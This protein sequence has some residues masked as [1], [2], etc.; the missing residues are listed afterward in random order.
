MLFEVLNDTDTS[1][2]ENPASIFPAPFITP[3]VC[4]Q[5]RSVAGTVPNLELGE[6][7]Q[8]Y[9]R[10]ALLGIGHIPTAL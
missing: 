4:R 6:S 9:V 10:I 3:P 8:Q 2:R 7:S 5:G 1:W